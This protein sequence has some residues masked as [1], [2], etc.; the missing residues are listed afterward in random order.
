VAF[1]VGGLFL[2]IG[3]G[4]FA[5]HI[6]AIVDV[7]RT[8]TGVWEA[9]QQSQ[10]LWAVLVIFLSVIGPVLYLLIARPQLQAA[11]GQGPIR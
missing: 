8:P 5:F 6:W 10:V 2:L 1:G 7:V 4:L 11:G 3:L 9:A